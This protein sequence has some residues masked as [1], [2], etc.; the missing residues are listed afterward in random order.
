MEN[1]SIQP[2]NMMRFRCPVVARD[3]RYLACAM[4][5]HKFWRNE[6]IQADCAAAMR[7]GKCPFVHMQQQEFLAGRPLF[8]DRVG[9]KLHRIPAAVMT[10]IIPVV[11]LR[12]HLMGEIELEQA[13]RMLEGDLEGEGIVR[14]GKTTPA[15]APTVLDALTDHLPDTAALTSAISKE[16]LA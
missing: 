12:S 3:S 13:T 16:A 7:A 1:S 9:E 2:D 15:K 14:K 10:R 6:P 5:K 4:R 11:V 8:V